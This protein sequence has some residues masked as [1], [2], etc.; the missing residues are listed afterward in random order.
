MTRLAGASAL[1]AALAW[2]LAPAATSAQSKMSLRPA[3]DVSQ[4][5]TDNVFYG[6]RNTQSDSVTRI[7]PRL[8]LSEDDS[9][10]HTQIVIGGT[11]KHY[12]T[13]DE[14]N[15]FDP[16]VSFDATRAVTDRLSVFSDGKIE[17]RKNTDAVE[18]SD[19][20][21]HG[22]QPD[23]RYYRFNGG[24]RYALSPATSLTSSLG[25]TQS[26]YDQGSG[27]RSSYSDSKILSLQGSVERSLS[28]RDS[29]G[30]VATVQRID[31]GQVE[32][33]SARSSRTDDIARVA[34][35]WSRI[36]TPRLSTRMEAGFRYLTT[37]GGQVDNLE[38][39]ESDGSFSAFDT[40][41]DDSFAFSGTAALNY[42]TL[43]GAVQMN[44]SQETRPDNGRQGSRDVT[45]ASISLTRRL[46]K[47]LSFR[48]GGAYTLS[49]SSSGVVQPVP[50]FLVPGCSRP[51]QE[52]GTD[53]VCLLDVE[54]ALDERTW[55]AWSE[56]SWQF[57][58]RWSTF[59]RYD[60]Q[61][62]SN[63]LPGDQDWEV[64]RVR[65]GVRW[66]HDLPL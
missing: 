48:A 61:R 42:Q 15:S 47:K 33:I 10:G 32:G 38:I 35:V 36:W 25:Y 37:D 23:V 31:L 64:N 40:T 2:S 53:A 43:K 62:Y 28:S 63:D 19:L 27:D 8:T 66:A 29:V 9:G 26:D 1:L 20:T 17:D 24:S 18:R 6:S 14:L 56:F 44:L 60:H 16:F 45:G 3:I 50:L 52:N 41:P 51:G 4:E 13:Y 7:L 57:S 46:L 11:S 54:S 30:L 58:R 34:A 59:V 49:R 21:L 39:E 12:N 55:T 65:V 5:W 22:R